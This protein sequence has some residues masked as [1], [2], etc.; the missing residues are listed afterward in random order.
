MMSNLILGSYTC[1]IFWKGD[2]GIEYFTIKFNSEETMR[3][4]AEQVN[5]QRQL[6]KDNARAS[7]KPG[8]SATEFLYMQGQGHIE[9]PYQ[10]QEE[11]DDDDLD[12]STLN[13]YPSDYP[14]G[15][16]ESNTSLRSRSTTGES[17]PPM[18]RMAPR[19]FPMGS[20]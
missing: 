4:W 18:S 11:E 15:R 10:Q 17:G 20:Q 8:V 16:N 3:K 9:N 7:A 1:Q 12:G 19:Q 6:W 13:N 14:I 5:T 2:P